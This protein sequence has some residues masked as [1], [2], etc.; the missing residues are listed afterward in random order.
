MPQAKGFKGIAPQEYGAVWNKY[1]GDKKYNEDK[2]YFDFVTYGAKHLVFWTFTAGGE[3]VLAKKDASYGEVGTRQNVW[4]A[5]FLPSGQLLSGGDNGKI[6]VWEKNKAIRELDAHFK[7]PLKCMR[8]RADEKTLL[9]SGGDGQVLQWNVEVKV[10]D[11]DMQGLGEVFKTQS[12][13]ITKRQL[14]LVKNVTRVMDQAVAAGRQLFETP[15]STR[16]ELFAAMDQD[17]D[18]NLN[19][20][21]FRGSVERLGLGLTEQQVGELWTIMDPGGD[22]ELDSDEFQKLFT[23]QGV[24]EKVINS[25]EIEMKVVEKFNL[26]VEKDPDGPQCVNC[27]DC[28]PDHDF[29][30]GADSENDIWEVDAEPRVMVEGQSGHVFGLSPHPTL[31]RVYATAC[32]DGHIG[33]WDAE[34][35]T[36]IKMIRVERGTLSA[37]QQ[38]LGMKEGEHLQAW[39]CTFNGDGTMLAVSTAGV[40]DDEERTHP[41]VGGSL[42]V[43]QCVDEMFT[44]SSD[45]MFNPTKLFEIKDMESV[46][47]DLKFSPDGKLLACCSH[48]RVVDIYTIDLEATP[49]PQFAH[50]GRCKGHSSTV[51]S[52]DWS[53]DSRLLRSCSVDNELMHWNVSGKLVLEEVRDASWYTWTCK[54][55]FS[56]MGI[57][58]K[59][60]SSSEINYCYRSH[61]QKWVVAAD[62]QG[63]V[64]LS[65]FPSVIQHAP[66]FAH[67]GHASHV[68]RVCFLSDDSRVISCGGADMA[69]YQ[70]KLRGPGKPKPKDKLK[71]LMDARAGA[72]GFGAEM[73]SLQDLA[74]EGA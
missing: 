2:H 52:L 53:D 61:N 50:V 8:L 38:K 45:K 47:D 44:P 59:G 35:R 24:L 15:F 63:F 68:E 42:I 28:H 54:V 62:H 64:R 48:D 27:I 65:N 7:G 9:T 19:K 67:R 18:N 14:E 6:M 32:A 22:G 56:V 33:V 3:P 49:T 71:G 21:E 70:W 51:V 60:M 43:Y 37:K 55:G 26:D 58:G 4:H 57:W 36:N 1:R 12:I 17:G 29:F 30:V 46:I 39:A 72:K 13:E 16:E 40:V 34:H 74:A 69:T 31:S 20:E 73:K 66:C 10:N 23:L 41:D 5:C 11:D 25:D